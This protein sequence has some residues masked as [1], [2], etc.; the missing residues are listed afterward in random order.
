MSSIDIRSYAILSAL[1]DQPR[2]GYAMLKQIAILFPTSK[3][4]AVATMYAALE[5]LEADGLVRVVSE[6]IVDGRA[7]RT[8]A[9]TD[10]GRDGLRAE[11][12]RMAAA[13]AIVKK[14][15]AANARTNSRPTRPAHPANPAT[16]ARS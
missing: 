9:L 11:A 10:H 7:R 12:E 8:F 4:P 5:R 16:G 3:R 15:L 13:A 6:E 2:H 1:I 14:K